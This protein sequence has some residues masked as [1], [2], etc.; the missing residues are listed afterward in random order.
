MKKKAIMSTESKDC[1]K[2]RRSK[3]AW[4]KPKKACKK[5]AYGQNTSHIL[6]V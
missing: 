1:P 2:R 5:K 3:I 4:M 6:F